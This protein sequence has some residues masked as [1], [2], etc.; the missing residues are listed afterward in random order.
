MGFVI[1]SDSEERALS[2]VE[3]MTIAVHELIIIRMRRVYRFGGF[4]RRAWRIHLGA[5]GY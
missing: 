5:I 1:L 4:Q 3:G 2:E